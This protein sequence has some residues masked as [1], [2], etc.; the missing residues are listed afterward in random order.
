MQESPGLITV[1]PSETVDVQNRSPGDHLLIIS[2]V[3]TIICFFVG[4]WCALCCTIPAIVFAVNVS[5]YQKVP[6]SIP[7]WIP[8]FSV[9]FVVSNSLIPAC[10]S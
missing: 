8:D 7:S 6:G 1:Q 10:I 5:R 9:L 2:V 4:S 3:L